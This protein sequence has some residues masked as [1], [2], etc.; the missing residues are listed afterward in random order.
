MALVLKKG[1]FGRNVDKSY[2]K[3][4]PDLRRKIITIWRQLKESVTFLSIFPIDTFRF[5]GFFFLEGVSRT[6]KTTKC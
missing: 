5:L 4:A 1:S 3:K 2:M 6:G